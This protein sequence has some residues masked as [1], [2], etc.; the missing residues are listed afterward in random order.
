MRNRLTFGVMTCCLLASTARGDDWPQWMGPQRDG[1][2]RESGI[3]ESLPSVPKYRWRTPVGA[4]YAGPAVAAGKVYI[5]DRV[6]AEGASNPENSFNRATVAG[7]E[8]VHCLD[9]STGKYLWTHSYDCPYR[10][11]YASGPR[12]TPIVEGDSVYTLGAMGDLMCLEAATGKVRWS[13]NL[14]EV[15]KAPEQIWGFA[16][17]PLID[18][19]RLI[20]LVGGE[21]AVVAFDKK[22]GKELWRSLESRTVGYCAPVIYDLAGRRQLVI[23]H[24]EAVNG[25][26]PESGQVLWLVPF[27]L[28]QSALSIPMPRLHRN[29]LFVTSFYNGS[30]MLEF[31]SGSATPKVLWKGKSNSEQPTR[32][33]GLHSIMP[34]PVLTD[35]HIF[36]VCSYGEL[37]CLKADTGERVWMTME[38]TRARRDGKM[39]PDKP[40]PT[41]DDRWGNAFLTPQGDRYWLFNEHGDLIVARLNEKGYEELGRWH[42]LEPDNRMAR[43]PVVWSHPAYANRACFVRN[44]SEIVCVDLAGGSAR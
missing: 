29:R 7:Q 9:A 24:P 43:H 36:G 44:D 3:V 8:R 33:D 1:V 40:E 41:G 15:Y 26:D 27:K 21:A 11:S 4:G 32:T 37:R 20:C 19:D 22:S 30:M 35:K 12:C 38:A 42:V 13:K 6:L 25:L 31:A 10:L 16:A 17:H 28:H 14:I 18:G 39:T 5:T 2:W 34:T 23:W